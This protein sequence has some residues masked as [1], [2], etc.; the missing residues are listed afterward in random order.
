MKIKD[1]YIDTLL[2]LAAASYAVAN[3]LLM[4]AAKLEAVE[5]VSEP[6]AAAP[7]QNPKQ[8]EVLEHIDVR[9]GETR[10][11]VPLC[12]DD[13]PDPDVFFSMFERKYGPGGICPLVIDGQRKNFDCQSLYILLRHIKQDPKPSALVQ[14]VYGSV[15]AVIMH[16]HGETP[17]TAELN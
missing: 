11:P 12:F 4:R 9:V 3:K 5:P 1:T 15:M 16:A 14:H 13:L 8:I 7:V 6:A 10:T 2:W 17:I